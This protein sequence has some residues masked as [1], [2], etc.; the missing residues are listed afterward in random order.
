V[1]FVMKSGLEERDAASHE[2]PL[3]YVKYENLITNNGAQLNALVPCHTH[4]CNR[5][6]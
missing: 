2:S 1:Y 4:T 3:A 5:Q 6:T